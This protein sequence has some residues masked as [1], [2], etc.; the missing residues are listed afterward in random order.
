MVVP[1][2]LAQ[3]AVAV[4][5]A[6]A[7]AEQQLLHWVP[8]DLAWSDFH[9]MEIAL[10]WRRLDPKGGP[11]KI[12]RSFLRSGCMTL[13]A[14]SPGEAILRQ[15]HPEIHLARLVAILLIRVQLSRLPSHGCKS[16]KCFL[17]SLN[18]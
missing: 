17:I 14:H 18:Y 4:A 10:L 16:C 15:R 11:I 2:K 12:I 7:A 6:Q 13:P 8:C 9:G 1:W 5:V 3:A